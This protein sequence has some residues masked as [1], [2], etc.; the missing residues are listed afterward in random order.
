MVRYIAFWHLDAYATNLIDLTVAHPIIILN[1]PLDPKC[2]RSPANVVTSNCAL[3]Y[4]TFVARGAARSGALEEKP[5]RN[6]FGSMPRVDIE[7][8]LELRELE[9]SPIEETPKDVPADSYFP[10]DVRPASEPKRGTSFAGL[11]GHS[12]AYYRKR[13]DLFELRK[14]ESTIC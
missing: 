14:I 3:P 9:P 10:S 12:P 8:P 2:G 1:F 4:P 6:T 5:Q 7:S 11:T 13:K